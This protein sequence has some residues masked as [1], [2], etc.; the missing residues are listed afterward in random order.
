MKNKLRLAMSTNVFGDLPLIQRFQKIAS[1]G[2]RYVLLGID[3][4]IS[5]EDAEAARRDFSRLGL[6]CV[7]LK[8]LDM[9]KSYVSDAHYA[10]A[11]G[12]IK[13]LGQIA[14]MYGASQIELTAGSFR[15]KKDEHLEAAVK[16]I[17][18]ACD[19]ASE[20]SQYCA[21]DFTPKKNQLIKTWKDMTELY[22]KVDKEN[23]L[24]NVNTA[25]LHHFGVSAEELEFIK[26]KSALLEIEDIEGD[27]WQTDINIGEGISDIA[28]WV[29]KA[30]PL[31]LES[32]KKT[33]SCPAALIVLKK[34]DEEEIKRTLRYLERVLPEAKL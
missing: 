31:I 29:D 24:I 22:G 21:L 25:L 30:M 9:P 26:G 1:F 14:K 11:I 18:E 13:K 23:L 2:I 5:N 16:F 3:K 6:K 12:E 19:I 32:C 4:D 15:G 8:S 34:S 17:A 27:G 33:G 20:S 10:E 28:S 7:Q